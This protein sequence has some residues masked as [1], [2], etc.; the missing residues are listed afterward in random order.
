MSSQSAGGPVGGHASVRAAGGVRRRPGDGQHRHPPVNAQLLRRR[1]QRP[2]SP[3]AI[4]EAY[5]NAKSLH[6]EEI[7]R[8][9]RGAA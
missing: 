8:L 1:R 7:L 4:R 5:M 6:V 2:P 3:A 9:A